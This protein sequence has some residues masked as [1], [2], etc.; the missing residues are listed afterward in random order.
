MQNERK[1]RPHD[2]VKLLEYV[3]LLDEARFYGKVILTFTDG[4][5][6]NIKQEQSLD[7]RKFLTDDSE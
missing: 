3:R 4:H 5:I 1:T 2:P 7:I 6:V